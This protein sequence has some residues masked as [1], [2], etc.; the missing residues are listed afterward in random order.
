M[1]HPSTFDRSVVTGAGSGLG[2]AIALRLARPGAQLLLADI[3]GAACA[4]TARLVVERGA[5]AHTQVVDVA[6]PAQVEA[7]AVEADRLLGRIDLVVNNAGVAFMAP[8]VAE[9]L[10]A[11][12]REVQAGG[13]P[14]TP[15]S[16]TATLEDGL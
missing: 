3:D 1:P 2:R 11:L 13:P 7:L 5:T 9:N 6:D 14:T 8:H 10:A 15:V 16:A 12:A 4:E